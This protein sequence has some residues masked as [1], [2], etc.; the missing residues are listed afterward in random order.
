MARLEGAD[1]NARLDELNRLMALQI[2]LA[3]GNQAR[4]ILE[5]H[6]LGF[7]LKRIAE[8]L[9]TT[10]NTVNVAIRKAN[11]RGRLDSKEA[12]T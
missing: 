12:T 1:V 9:G 10:S 3:I 5:L 8:L 4:T 6:R 7:S 2:R 11:R